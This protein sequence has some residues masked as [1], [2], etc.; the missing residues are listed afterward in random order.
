MSV[1]VPAVAPPEPLTGTVAVPPLPLDVPAL[2]ATVNEDAPPTPPLFGV[3]PEQ[4]K[5]PTHTAAA[6][7]CPSR[8]RR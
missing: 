8:I 3:S 6:S 7:H 4:A 5:T 1:V 2:P